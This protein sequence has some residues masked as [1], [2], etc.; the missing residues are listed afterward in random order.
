MGGLRMRSSL[1][2]GD[3]QTCSPVFMSMA[4]M[5][6]YGG[7]HSGRPCGMGTAHRRG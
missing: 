6:E 7:F 3:I 1:P 4:V 2:S 5:H